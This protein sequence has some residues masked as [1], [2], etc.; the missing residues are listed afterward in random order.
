MW[1]LTV[2]LVS[3]I[4]LSGCS[5]TAQMKYSGSGTFHQL[6]NARNQCIAQDPCALSFDSC[7]A[8]KGFYRSPNGH[9]D[10]SN[11]MIQ[12]A[13]HCNAGR[14]A[15]MQKLSKDLIEYSKPRRR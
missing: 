6:L 11:M 1:K 2:S 14:D 5:N 13:S 15:A 3:I 9:L 10:V 4:I 8:A 7:V 12:K